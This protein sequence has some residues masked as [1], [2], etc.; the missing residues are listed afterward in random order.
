MTTSSASST[1]W[2]NWSTSTRLV[3][4]AGAVLAALV[5]AYLYA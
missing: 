1:N 2:R 5:V 4:G 3:V